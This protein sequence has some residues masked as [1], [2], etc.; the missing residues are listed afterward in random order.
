[1]DTKA[2]A[3]VDNITVC[4]FYWG[5]E[6]AQE[7]GSI[8]VHK[9]YN[10]VQRHLTIPHRFVCF[11]NHARSIFSSEIEIE[12]INKPFWRRNLPK[13]N[14]YSKNNHLTGRVLLLDLD[15]IILKNINEF[16]TASGKFIVGDKHMGGSVVAFDTNSLV[17]ELWQPAKH[18]IDK[19]SQYTRG[20]ER[21]Y[22][23]EFAKEFV[24][25][26]CIDLPYKLISYKKDYLGV[27]KRKWRKRLQ[28]NININEEALQ[29]ASIVYFHGN[30]KP[31]NEVNRFKWIED[32]WR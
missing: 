10:M 3:S 6:W 8:Y 1:M 14:I 17:K 23:K 24:S 9:L 7:Q 16:A 18:N 32:N 11:T 22:Y 25:F 30:P 15:V 5:N 26:W 13:L 21:A 4:C 28:N 12:K 19:I 27:K 29:K 2:L 20:S 31:H